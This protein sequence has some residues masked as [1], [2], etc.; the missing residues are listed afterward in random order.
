MSR[1]AEA[2]LTRLKRMPAEDRATK[3][4]V[5]DLA[6]PLEPA[7]AAA[8][9]RSLPDQLAARALREVVARVVA[10]HHAG[11]PVVVLAATWS[12]SAWC[13]ACWNSSI[14]VS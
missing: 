11:R 5:A 12:R 1:F 13:R 7:A 8:L 14:V 6:K 3:V 10:A 4:D 9:L 2:D